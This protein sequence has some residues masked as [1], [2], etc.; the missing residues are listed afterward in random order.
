VS[1]HRGHRISDKDESGGGP[2]SQQNFVRKSQILLKKID[3]S[4]SETMMFE[5]ELNEI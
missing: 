5:E 2:N 1:E 4:T 3:A